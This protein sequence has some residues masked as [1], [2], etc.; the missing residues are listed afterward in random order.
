MRSHGGKDREP[1]SHNQLKTM[2]EES[3]IRI[4]FREMLRENFDLVEAELKARGIGKP[5]P[6]KMALS[7]K[8]AAELTGLSEPTIRRRVHAGLIPA[9]PGISPTRIPSDFVE[10]MMKPETAHA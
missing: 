4:L 1:S 8:E 6:T 10:R 9:V 5:A 7:V 2:P 3:P